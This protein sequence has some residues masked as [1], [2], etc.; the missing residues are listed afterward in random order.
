MSGRYD[1]GF[2][3]NYFSL[4]ISLGFIALFSLLASKDYKHN[5]LFKMIGFIDI[6]FLFISLLWLGS[7]GVIIS[8]IVSLAAIFVI[9]TRTKKQYILF[10]AA[11]VTIILAA[12]TVPGADIVINRFQDKSTV[13]NL[14]YRLPL[15]IK[16]YQ[17]LSEASLSELLLG[18]GTNSGM[19]V[20]KG[21]VFTHATSPHNQYLDF[22][23]D[24]GLLGLISFLTIFYL[25]FKNSFKCS[26]D[27]KTVRF[28][29]LT[30]FFLSSFT[31]TPFKL[32]VLPWLALGFTLSKPKMIYTNHN[33][34]HE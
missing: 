19:Q 10:I 22:A 11:V 15:A 14:S 3:Q 21:V 34:S 30:F 24:Y 17:H 9:Q 27:D 7:R 28:A 33:S 26:G 23:L 25:G 4:F 2:D 8:L 6:G 1:V 16:A 31:L 29:I 5:P 12:L 20:L 32:T 18:G 13:S